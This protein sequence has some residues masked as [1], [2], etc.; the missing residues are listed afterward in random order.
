MYN[1]L[2]VDDEYLARNKL[3]FLLDWNKYGFQI[4]GEASTAEDAIAF[5]RENHV[6]VVFADVYMQ[7]MDGIQLEEYI[8]KN[9]PDISVV[10]FS[11]YSDFNYVK[12]A[13][14]AN[15]IDYVLKYTELQ[16]IISEKSVP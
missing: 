2:I 16:K 14:S 11:N 3:H 8:N 10:I 5:I 9:Y 15:V 12:S 1:I 7:D 4:L 6:D 13:F